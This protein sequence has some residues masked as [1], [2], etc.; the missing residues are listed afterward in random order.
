MATR[1]QDTTRA[2]VGEGQGREESGDGGVLGP[3]A[4]RAALAGVGLALLVRGVRRRSLRGIGTALAGGWLLTRAI[5]SGNGKREARGGAG[6]RGSSAGS[7][8]VSRTISVGK[9]ADELY[10]AWRD[11]ET[12]ARVMSHVADVTPSANDRHHWTVHTPYGRAVSWETRI[13]EDDPGQIVRWATPGDAVVSH[14]GAVRFRE[15]AGG[16]GTEMTLTVS[17]DPPGG[18]LGDAVLKRLGMAPEMLVGQALARFKSLVESGEI[19]TLEGNP[20]ARG[21]GDLL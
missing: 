8:A 2:R 18:A 5:R 3:Q 1:S 4:K 13:V 6:R 11:P 10:E 15:A 21:E 9:S 12:F 14:E 19:P 7:A 16:R 17:F 20:S